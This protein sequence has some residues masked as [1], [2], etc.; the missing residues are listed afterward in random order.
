MFRGEFFSECALDHG[1]RGEPV[2]M[3]VRPMVSEYLVLYGG[4]SVLS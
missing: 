1:R 2:F 3:V 4:A